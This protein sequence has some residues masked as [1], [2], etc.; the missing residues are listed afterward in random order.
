M[1]VQ[2]VQPQFIIKVE[3]SLILILWSPSGGTNATASGLSAGSYTVTVSDVNGCS[4]VSSVTI[5]APAVLVATE[6]HTDV[7][8]NGGSTGTATIS[9]T[10]GTAPYTGLVLSLV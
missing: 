6:A 9:A 3:H 8:C 7:L 5:T 2:M 4:S 10:G 1:V